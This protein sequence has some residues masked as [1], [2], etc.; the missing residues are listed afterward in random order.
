MQ[1]ELWQ[2][3]GQSC[4]SRLPA[5]DADLDLAVAGEPLCSKKAT[6]DLGNLG[7]P[8]HRGGI[9]MGEK[10]S[11]DWHARRVHRFFSSVPRYGMRIRLM[12]QI[13]ILIFI[14]RVAMA[15]TGVTDASGHDPAMNNI[16]GRIPKQQ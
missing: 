7:A 5:D 9:Q 12:K 15:T 14:T 2:I 4:S 16:V 13:W 10:G 3:A 8:R 1:R 6:N 11:C